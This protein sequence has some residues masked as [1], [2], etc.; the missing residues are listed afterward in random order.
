MIEGQMQW[1]DITCGNQKKVG[2]GFESGPPPFNH[3]YTVIPLSQ[4]EIDREPFM[5]YGKSASEQA[6]RS[7][8][9]ILDTSIS[10]SSADK[11]DNKNQKSDKSSTKSNGNKQICFNCGTTGHIARNC[12]NRMFVHHMS[13]RGENESRGR[14][15]IRKSSRT[16]SRDDDWKTNQNKKM[17]SF[18]KNKHVFNKFTNSLP[19]ST[20]AK[21]KSISSKSRSGTSNSSS[22]NS[23]Y[24]KQTKKK[25]ISKPKYQW[26]PKLKSDQSSSSSV[27]IEKEKLK[28]ESMK[29][30]GQPRTVMTCVLKSK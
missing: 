17:A 25:T 27:S 7:N 28:D 20:Q 24:S 23:T 19:K 1:K 16:R 29:V 18:Q 26:M 22:R 5:V 11:K 13:K 8:D 21:P 4:E 3:T 2:L 12:L 15:L 9:K 6:T 10:T 30:K 14:S